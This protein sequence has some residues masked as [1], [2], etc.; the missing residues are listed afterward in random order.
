LFYSKLRKPDRRSL[1]L[2]TISLWTA[3]ASQVLGRIGT[4]AYRSPALARRA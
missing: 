4:V 1:R 2:C 3:Y